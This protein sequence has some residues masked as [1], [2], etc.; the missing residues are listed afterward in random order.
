MNHFQIPTDSPPLPRT[1]WVLEGKFLAGAYAGQADRVNHE[2]RIRGLFNAGMRTIVNLMEVD[3]S[4]NDGKPFAP[5]E[6]LLQEFAAEAGKK[7]ECFRFPIVDVM[8]LMFY[9]DFAA[10]TLQDRHG[11]HQ[12]MICNEVLFS[13]GKRMRGRPNRQRRNLTMIGLL[14]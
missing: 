7:V 11:Q 1:Y 9:K 8:C 3:E 12:K 13:I 4:N 14:A 6:E 10:P 5:Y 2:M